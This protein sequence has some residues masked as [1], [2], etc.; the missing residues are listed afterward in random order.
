MIIENKKIIE[1]VMYAFAGAILGLILAPKSPTVNYI[2]LSE[3]EQEQL[4]KPKTPKMIKKTTT[5]KK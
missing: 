4:L 1:I 2:V 3:Q 5:K